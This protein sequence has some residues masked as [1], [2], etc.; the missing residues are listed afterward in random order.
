M[1]TIRFC[2]CGRTW[3]CKYKDHEKFD[4]ATYAKKHFKLKAKKH[5]GFSEDRCEQGQFQS[6]A[7]KKKWK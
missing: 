6:G 1:T 4:S 5:G 3:P 7:D 2:E